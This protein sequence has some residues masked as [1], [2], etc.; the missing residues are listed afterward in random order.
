MQA[1]L[2]KL[3]EERQELLRQ[4]ADETHEKRKKMQRKRGWGKKHGK[5]ARKA[6]ILHVKV[7]IDDEIIEIDQSEGTEELEETE[8]VVGQSEDDHDYD[9]ADEN[10]GD[11]HSEA[12]PDM[13]DEEDQGASSSS[14]S[15]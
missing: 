4:N 5:K 1:E 8:N 15:F 7:K 3:K 13:E 6:K 9:N 2:Q 14:F 10:S 11:D 12:D